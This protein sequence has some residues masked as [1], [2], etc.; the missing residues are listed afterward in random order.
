M[1]MRRQRGMTLIGWLI[2]LMIVAVVGLIGIRL[3]PLYME[4]YAV[5]SVLRSMES[6]VRLSDASYSELR[7]TFRKRLDINSVD[8]VDGDDLDFNDVAGGVQLLV[9]Y[10]VRVHLLGNLDAVANFRREAVIR[11]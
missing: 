7:E 9:D 6:E 3:I 1:M 8:G 2:T 5:G 11:K 10:E 4:A